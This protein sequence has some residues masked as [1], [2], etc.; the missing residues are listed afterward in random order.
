MKCFKPLTLL[1]MLALAGC[2]ASSYCEGEHAYQTAPSVP[3]VQSAEGLKFPESTAALKIPPAPANPVPYGQKVKMDDG[4]E[5]TS[6][7]DKPPMLVTPT[8]PPEPP[9]PDT[10]APAQPPAPAPNS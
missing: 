8:L 6:C 2:A 9:K 5:R 4:D 7:L 10:P 1:P 3:A